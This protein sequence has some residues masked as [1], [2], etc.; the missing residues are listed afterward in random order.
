MGVLGP[1]LFLLVIDS[2]AECGSGSKP[3]MGIFADDTRIAK[4][5]AEETDAMNLQS[6]LED[7][8]DW[9]KAN[10]ME[11]NGSKF[12]SLK[13]GRNLELKE[14][15]NYENS[16]R[17]EAIEDVDCTRD[18]GIEMATDGTYNNHIAK[19]FKKVRRKMG[20]VSRSFFRN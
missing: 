15:Y 5:I 20:W 2:L 1:L 13:Y 4:K 11:F 6:D 9:A 3:D 16:D 14:L 12:Q 19:I 10:N 17:S 8:Y 18:L 7:L